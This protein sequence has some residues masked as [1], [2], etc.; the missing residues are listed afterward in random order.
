MN[1]KNVMFHL[2]EA[3]EQLDQTIIAIE[4][5]EDFDSTVFLSDMSHLYHHLNTA[6]NSQ[7]VDDKTINKC[8][9]K[10]I[11]T[12][13]N[14]PGLRLNRSIPKSAVRDFNEYV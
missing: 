9:D 3:K 7:N 4:H 5:D 1:K 13:P 14:V 8:S 12:C 11:G 6:W 2:K 10:Y